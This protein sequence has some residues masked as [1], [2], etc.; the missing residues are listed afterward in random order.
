MA[1]AFQNQ[2]ESWRLRVQASQAGAFWRWWTAELRAMLPERL[3]ERVEHAQRRVV[4][5]LEGEELELYW[6]EGEV[7][8][9]LEV[10]PADEDLALQRQRIQDLL[11]ERELNE[12]PSELVLPESLV[13]RKKLT[14]PLAAEAN[15][16]Q[17][18]GFEMDRHTPFRADDVCFDYRVL[19]RDKERG[20]LKLELV[21]VPIGPL[22][23]QV[24]TLTQRGLPP[25]AVDVVLD[26]EPAGLNLLP[27]E[28]RHR[29]SNRRTRMNWLLAAVAVLLLAVVM[30]QSLWLREGQIEQLEAAI[31]EVRVEARRVQNIRS[32]IED[33]SEAAGFMLARRAET[34]PTVLVMAE[35]TRLLPD[36]TYLDRLRVWEGNVQMQ[37]KSDNAQRLIE[38]VNTSVL[39]DGAGFRGSTR[40]DGQTQKEIFD[41]SARIEGEGG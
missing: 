17:A 20:Q 29:V 6:Q 36:D 4:A 34:P 31:E 41:L 32:Q 40:L 19:Q 33:A 16:R 39:L 8:Q 30:A 3:R 2:L 15:L 35:V 24:E 18:L 13:L 14:L 9:Q 26:G 25:S 22:N 21:V 23:Q 37:G 12:S 1:S 11:A 7:L 28:R 10:F 27:P 5:R 38:L